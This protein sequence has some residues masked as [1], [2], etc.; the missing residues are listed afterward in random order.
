[1]ASTGTEMTARDVMTSEP[2]CVDPTMSI[3]DLAHVFD[4]DEISGVP[5]VDAEGTLIGVVTK[6]DLIRKCLDGSIET[7]PAYL[8]ASL[9][10]QGTYD[11]VADV[12]PD[13]E[14]HAEEFMTEDPVTA[15]PDASLPVLARLMA[16]D[17]IHRIVIVDES[18]YPLGIVTS[19][20]LLSHWAR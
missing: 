18:G 11:E 16:E 4:E 5:V 14:I 7:P 9:G 15:G 8:F 10:D 12:S 19:L 20:D 1:M 17:G 13:A 2:V 6:T 3:Y